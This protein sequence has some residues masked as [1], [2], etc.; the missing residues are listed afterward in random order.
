MKKIF[1]IAAVLV[2][3][4]TANAKTWRIN[5][6]EAAKPDFTTLKAACEANKV[7]KGDSLYCEPGIYTNS[8]DNY[9]TKNG[10]TILGPGFG[11][12]GNVGSTS[13]NAEAYFS[14]TLRLQADT[15]HIVG[16]KAETIEFVKS[17]L[18]NI[19][20]ER[21]YLNDIYDAN[22]RGG[23]YITIRDNFI[24]N[25]R[26]YNAV[27][28]EGNSSCP[29][30][31]IE[32]ENNIIISNYTSAYTAIRV[33]ASVYTSALIAHNTIV[34]DIKYNSSNYSAIMADYSVIRDNI[35][36]NTNST[37]AN[38]YILNSSSISTCDVYNNVFSLTEDNADAA[39]VSAYSA[40]NS[41]AGAT[42]AN[43]FTCTK[44]GEA[45]A[46]YYQLKDGSVAKNKAYQG[47]DCGAFAGSW[48]FV[49]EGRPQGLPYIY[50]VYAPTTPTD[51][52][53]TITFKVKANNE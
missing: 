45:E 38:S 37:L 2:A 47:E 34:V 52:K 41:F 6:N 8:S 12:K 39:F 4:V 33:Q 46:T 9:I 17:S 19:T 22:S 48:P 50:D 28:L 44:I 1:F 13:T 27:L 35:I 32:I 15:L 10:L 30:Q 16:I 24:N 42:T 5:P 29:L 25:K 53:L 40:K 26:A 36:I 7:T 21:C 11:Y 49:V 18:K 31:N 43:T 3:S 14:A 23:Q 51:D 20:I